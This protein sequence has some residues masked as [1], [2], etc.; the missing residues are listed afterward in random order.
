M[1]LCLPILMLG[2]F[3]IISQFRMEDIMSK[4][5]IGTLVVTTFLRV[6]ASRERR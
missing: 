6:S 1:R 5:R 3:L 4:I 2:I